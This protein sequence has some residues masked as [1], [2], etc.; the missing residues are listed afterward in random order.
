MVL[1]RHHTRH[2][3]G[4]GRGRG[5]RRGGAER[6]DAGDGGGQD[7]YRSQRRGVA[8]RSRPGTRFFPLS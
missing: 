8:S 1:N 2:A 7:D 6:I 4:T 5:L 3:R